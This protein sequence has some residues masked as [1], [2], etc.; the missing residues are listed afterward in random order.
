MSS[1]REMKSTKPKIEELLK[2]RPHLRDDDNKLIANIWF[3]EVDD[4]NIT[5]K[6]FLTL[7]A[8]GGLTSPES[9]RRMRAKLQEESPEYRGENYA[10]RHKEKD[11]VT[12]GINK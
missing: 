9:I 8:E 10:A 2:S 6:E 12:E 7:F 3:N 5:A 1:L 11:V 4:I